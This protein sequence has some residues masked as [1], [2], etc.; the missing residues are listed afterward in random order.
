MNAKKRIVM[1]LSTVGLAASLAVG[2]AAVANA[3]V[4][5]VAGGTWDYGVDYWVMNTHSNYYQ[6]S[7]LHNSTACSS[8]QCVGSGWTPPGVLAR[9][10]VH[11]TWGGNTAWYNLY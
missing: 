7:R 3:A 2:G 9:A 10:N 8:S 4:V 5:S 11:A 1:T 6:G